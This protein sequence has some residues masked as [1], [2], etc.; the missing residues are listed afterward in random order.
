MCCCDKHASLTFFLQQI[1]RAG[2]CYLFTRVQI[3][4]PRYLNVVLVIPES[5]ILQ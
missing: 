5:F 4:K 1:S 2:Y 3:F